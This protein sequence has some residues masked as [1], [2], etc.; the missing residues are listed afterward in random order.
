MAVPAARSRTSLS[1]WMR[2]RSVFP[3]RDPAVE[4]PC[5]RAL[6]SARSVS[7]FGA[8]PSSL[9]VVELPARA[10]LPRVHAHLP[11]MRKR[12]SL[13]AGVPPSLLTARAAP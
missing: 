6:I 12:S 3:C 4:F 13:L 11:S 7:S 10:Y 2:E 9:A 5:T 1:P 8:W